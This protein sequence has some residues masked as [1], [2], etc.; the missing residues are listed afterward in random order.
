MSRLGKTR[1]DDGI[2]GPGLDQRKRNKL[3]HAL[4][5]PLS[6]EIPSSV[7][8]IVWSGKDAVETGAVAMHQE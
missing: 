4:E 7:P 1:A 5:W 6:K 8:G 3:V 2:R